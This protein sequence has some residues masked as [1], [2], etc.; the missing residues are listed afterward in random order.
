MIQLS[1]RVGVCAVENLTTRLFDVA[2]IMDDRGI[3][4]VR[5][6]GGNCTLVTPFLRAER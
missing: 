1:P 3:S 5:R 4:F 6:Y 2:R